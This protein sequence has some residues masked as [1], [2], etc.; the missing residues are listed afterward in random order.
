MLNIAGILNKYE[1]DYILLMA[2]AVYRTGAI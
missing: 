1:V 2:F